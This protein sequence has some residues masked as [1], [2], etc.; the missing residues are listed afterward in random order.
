LRWP[1]PTPP[2]RT[3]TPACPPGRCRPHSAHRICTQGEHVRAQAASQSGALALRQHADPCKQC[4]SLLLPCVYEH[5]NTQALR[6]APS[7]HTLPPSLNHAHMIKDR[8]V[9]SLTPR[10][11][12]PSLYHFIHTHIARPPTAT[13]VRPQWTCQ[14][15]SL[16]HFIHTHTARPPT[17]TAVRPRWTCQTPTA[18]RVQSRCPWAG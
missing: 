17:A 14:T 2:S 9:F 6:P 12:S 8:T 4:C 7:H 11:T 5:P 15:P 16:Y 1:L 10:S 13:A 3:L 18:L